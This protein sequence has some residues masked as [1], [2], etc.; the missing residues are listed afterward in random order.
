MIYKNLFLL[1]EQAVR[2]NVKI[3]HKIQFR[4]LSA[5]SPAIFKN[6]MIVCNH[7]MK[8]YIPMFVDKEGSIF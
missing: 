2:M 3:V 6:N 8:I 7:S 4:F 5:V 1:Y